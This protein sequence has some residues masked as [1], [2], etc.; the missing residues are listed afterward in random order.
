MFSLFKK[1]LSDPKLQVFIRLF[2]AK[3]VCLKQHSK[4]ILSNSAGGLIC[5]SCYSSPT[6][7]VDPRSAIQI[8]ASLPR[9]V[10]LHWVFWKVSYAECSEK[11][12]IL[13]FGCFKGGHRSDGYPSTWNLGFEPMLIGLQCVFI[14]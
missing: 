8:E 12:Y 9:L 7:V 5:N 4:L 3:S 6:D 13:Y 11:N 10:A 1:K 14:L 2:I